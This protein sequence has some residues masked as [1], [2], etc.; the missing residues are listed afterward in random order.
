M[1]GE[2][3]GAD[4]STRRMLT[5]LELTRKGEIMNLEYLADAQDQK[6]VIDRMLK[7]IKIVNISNQ[8]NNDVK[9]YKTYTQDDKRLVEL[10]RT[11]AGGLLK[12]DESKLDYPNNRAK[13]KALSDFQIIG[14][15]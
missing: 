3:K 4:N 6:E 8:M 14:P 10:A 1:P 2:M 15:R 11:Q 5:S 9:K 12:I 7:A 13:P